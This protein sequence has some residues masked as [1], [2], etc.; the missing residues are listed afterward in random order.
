MSKE[1]HHAMLPLMS[2]GVWWSLKELSYFIHLGEII[3]GFQETNLSLG[4]ERSH[5]TIPEMSLQVVGVETQV[6][7]L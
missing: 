2:S 1:I 5:I 3:W 4:R 7:L 6:T